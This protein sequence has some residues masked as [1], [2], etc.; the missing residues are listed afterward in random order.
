[1]QSKHKR[2]VKPTNLHKTK[3]NVFYSYIRT[4]ST[5]ISA[6]VTSY[7]VT[8]YIGM[9]AYSIF[10]NYIARSYDSLHYPLLFLYGT[11]GWHVG[12]SNV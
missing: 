11:D 7:S 8:L 12:D 6:Q 10:Q 2:Y 4:G 9:V 5:G 1:M 3:V